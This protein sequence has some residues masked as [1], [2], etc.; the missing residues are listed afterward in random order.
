LALL[1]SLKLPSQSLNGAGT[2][3]GIGCINRMA[4]RETAQHSHEGR[5]RISMLRMHQLFTDCAE[6]NMT[7]WPR[8]VRDE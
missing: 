3:I 6:C 4:T 2:D 1:V 7:K 8:S 5:M